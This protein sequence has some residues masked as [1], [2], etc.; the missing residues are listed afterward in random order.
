M[1]KFLYFASVAAL[2]AACTP[3]ENAPL[4]FGQAIT[5]GVSIGSAPTG[6][7]PEFTLGYRDANL[8]IIPTLMTGADGGNEQI[9]GTVAAATDPAT[10]AFSTFGQFEG[11]MEGAKVGLNKFFAT[12]LAAQK[13]ADG[14][15]CAV[16]DGKAPTCK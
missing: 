1:K 7:T 12:G 13:L 15:A 9:G 10:D 5:V 3:A 8:A 6:Q 11:S 14:F 16:S 2:V 4:I